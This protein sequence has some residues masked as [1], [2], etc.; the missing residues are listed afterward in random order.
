MSIRQIMQLNDYPEG[1]YISTFYAQSV[2]LVEF[3][4][5]EKGP[6]ELTQF[7][8]EGMHGG[9]EAALRRHYGIQDFSDLEQRWQQ[10]ALGTGK[11]LGVAERGR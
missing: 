4:S 3:L 6:Q 2:S 5:R 1:R 11:P 10:Y 9:Y 7:L 8:R